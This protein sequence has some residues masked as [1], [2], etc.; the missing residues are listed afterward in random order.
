MPNSSSRKKKVHNYRNGTYVS[1]NGSTD[2]SPY[3]LKCY[4]MI[5]SWIHKKE[6]DI[7]TI[8]NDEKKLATNDF[9]SAEKLS[10]RIKE[11][12]K[13]SEQFIIILNNL[14]NIDNRWT[15]YE[16][17]YAVD[18]CGI[19]IIVVYIDTD[20]ILDP[21]NYHSY[22][23]PALKKR[24]ISGEASCIHIPF[25]KEPFKDAVTQFSKNRKPNGASFGVYSEKAYD[26][27][28]IKIPQPKFPTLH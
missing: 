20:Y 15:Q 13:N 7:T 17:E 23:P 5:K 24:I 12:I 25:R 6:Y 11:Y 26:Y 22:W 21:I 4:S 18:H 16:I 8:T 27:F 2:N 9:S 1:F 14:S 28:G 3:H 19:P 10:M